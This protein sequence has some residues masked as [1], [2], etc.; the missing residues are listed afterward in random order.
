MNSWVVNK[1]EVMS[2]AANTRSNEVAGLTDETTKA[3]RDL[4]QAPILL[5]RKVQDG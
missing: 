2:G 3:D 5:S 4:L 1:P